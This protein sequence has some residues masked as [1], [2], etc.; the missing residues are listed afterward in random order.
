MPIYNKDKAPDIRIYDTSTGSIQSVYNQA[1]AD[2]ADMIV[3]PLRQS[4]VES[5]TTAP[6]LPIPTLALNRLDNRQLPQPEN[7]YQFGLSPLD[8]L[9][10]S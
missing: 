4:Q 2:E 7:F 9:T 6:L 10:K 3:G 5:L 8:E 1:V